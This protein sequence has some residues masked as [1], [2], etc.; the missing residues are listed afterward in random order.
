[1]ELEITFGKYKLV[2]KHLIKIVIV[3]SGEAYLCFQ[4]E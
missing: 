2:V 3:I 1:M 4:E